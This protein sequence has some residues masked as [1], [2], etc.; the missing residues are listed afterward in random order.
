MKKTIVL[1][2][3]DNVGTAEFEEIKRWLDGVCVVVRAIINEPIKVYY[4]E[5]STNDTQ[6]Q[7]S[8]RTQSQNKGATG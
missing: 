6:K 7:I 1:V 8:K 4:L 2:S 3:Y 5:E